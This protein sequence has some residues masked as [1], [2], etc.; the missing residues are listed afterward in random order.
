MVFLALGV[1][2]RGR[3]DILGFVHWARFAGAGAGFSGLHPGRLIGDFRSAAAQPAEHKKPPDLSVERFSCRPWIPRGQPPKER[4]GPRT[5]RIAQAARKVKPGLCGSS[6]TPWGG[7]P[8][9][10]RGREPPGRRPRAPREPPAGA[11]G[12]GGGSR[13]EARTVQQLPAAHFRLPLLCSCR[14]FRQQ[15][16][17]W[18]PAALAVDAQRVC[19]GLCEQAQA[20]AVVPP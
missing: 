15:G 8:K 16:A 17:R 18:A 19:R 7:P 13:G 2:G 14:Q 4:N 12:A 20:A 10:G 6:R 5:N 11:A 9:A 3:V 1:W